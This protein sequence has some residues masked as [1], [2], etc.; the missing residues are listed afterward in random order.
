MKG[1]LD[2]IGFH[3]CPCQDV[4]RVEPAG[5]PRT[6]VFRFPR[7]FD[8]NGNGE[9]QWSP[10]ADIIESWKEFL[11]KAELP[12][13]E[14]SDINVSIDD[15]RLTIEGERKHEKEDSDETC[16]RIESF[17]VSFFRSFVLPTNIDTSR[18]SAKYKNGILRVHLP[19]TADSRPDKA[20][21]IKID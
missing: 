7:I 16:H 14:K 2:P 9:K 19:K 4:R 8:E 18:I 5:T 15:G 1:Q 17:Y 10:S 3:R 20:K 6:P 13:V 21:A 12:D 11:I